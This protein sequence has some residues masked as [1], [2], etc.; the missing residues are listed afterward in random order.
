MGVNSKIWRGRVIWYYVHIMLNKTLLLALIVAAFVSLVSCDDARKRAQEN[1]PP[2]LQELLNELPGQLDSGARQVG[3]LTKEQFISMSTIEYKVFDLPSDEPAAVLQERLMTLG[4]D[5]WDCSIIH[6]E[7]GS[8]RVLCK[9]YPIS[10]LK[11]LPLLGLSG[12]LH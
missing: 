8:V 6:A 12:L 10:F 1:I 7:G 9:K 11:L 5:R 4:K 3:S 2:D